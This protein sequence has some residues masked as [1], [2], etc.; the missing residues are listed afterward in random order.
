MDDVKFGGCVITVFMA[1]TH[2]PRLGYLNN[3]NLFLIV[4]EVGKSKIKVPVNLEARKRA[5]I[6]TPNGYLLAMSL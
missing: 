2:H 5:F 4:Q 6:G 1:I 3:G